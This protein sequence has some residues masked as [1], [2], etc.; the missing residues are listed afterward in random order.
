MSAG[1]EINDSN[2]PGHRAVHGKR[3]VSTDR[4]RACRDSNDSVLS[5][6]GIAVRG[7]Q[8][9]RPRHAEVAIA[10]VA[11]PLCGLNGEEA[12]S[13]NSNIEQIAGCQ[14]TAG[15]K[16]EIGAFQH[17]EAIGGHIEHIGKSGP[18]VCNQ[19]LK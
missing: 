8:F 18:R 14:K 13:F 4:N 15:L 6:D 10:G 11:R 5:E 17:A 3:S 1:S 2:F 19:V 12:F 7:N 9:A 16:I